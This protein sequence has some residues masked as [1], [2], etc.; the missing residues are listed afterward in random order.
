MGSALLVLILVRTNF[1]GVMKAL[2]A[3]SWTIQKVF[4]FQAGMLIFRGIVFGNVLGLTFYFLQSNLSLIP[5]NPEVYYLDTV[6][7]NLGILPWA[8]LNIGTLLVCLTALIIP[9]L[10]I[11]RISPAKSIRFN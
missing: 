10:V 8:L 1:I 3:T 4:L 2:G 7:L 9:S 11:T 6:P 5:L